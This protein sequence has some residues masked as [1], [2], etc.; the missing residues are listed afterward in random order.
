MGLPLPSHPSSG[1]LQARCAGEQWTSFWS[2]GVELGG[3]SPGR[4]LKSSCEV[5]GRP[6]SSCTPICSKV[7]VLAACC[8]VPCTEGPRANFEDREALQHG[9]VGFYVCSLSFQ[10]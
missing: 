2:S 10:Y 5:G 9:T 4:F 7:G 8:L 6:E 1:T 3:P